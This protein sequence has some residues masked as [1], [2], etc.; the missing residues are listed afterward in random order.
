MVTKLEGSTPIIQKPTTG[1]DLEPFTSQFTIYI[2]RI[3]T[4]INIPSMGM[5]HFTYFQQDGAPP[6]YH[7]DFIS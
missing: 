1:H 5:S 6:H 2:P 7:R 4:I 3:L